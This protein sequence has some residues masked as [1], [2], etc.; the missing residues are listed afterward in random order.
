MKVAGSTH[1]EVTLAAYSRVATEIRTYRDV[2]EKLSYTRPWLSEHIPDGEDL[3][4]PA[5]PA[6]RERI[7]SDMVRRWKE[8]VTDAAVAEALDA[9]TTMLRSRLTRARVCLGLNAEAGRSLL[10]YALRRRRSE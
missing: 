2:L 10:Y 4:D 7:V 1:K 8:E 9:A 5:S 6:L 3:D